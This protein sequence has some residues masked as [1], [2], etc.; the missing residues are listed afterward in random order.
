M[1][2][3]IN[4]TVFLFI[5]ALMLGSAGCT[6]REKITGGVDSDLPNFV[7]IVAD[8][9]GTNDLGCYGNIAVKTPNLDYLATEGIRFTQAYCT[10]ASCS[11]SRSVIL[12]IDTKLS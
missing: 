5:L 9:H 8:D 10:S 12:S 11:A 2:E 1:N 7:L 6:N 4:K 3:S